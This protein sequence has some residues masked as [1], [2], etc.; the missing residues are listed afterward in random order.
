MTEKNYYQNDPDYAA[1]MTLYETGDFNGSLLL[2]DDLL[3]RY[4]KEAQL[5]QFKEDVELQIVLHQF[6]SARVRNERFQF[7]IILMVMATILISVAALL[8]QSLEQYRAETLD[9]LREEQALI[10]AQQLSSIALL[11]TQAVTFLTADKYEI[12]G[13]I[14]D[15]I[16]EIDADY[17]NLPVLRETQTYFSYLESLYIQTLAHIEA[18]EYTEAEQTLGEI[19]QLSENYRDIAQLRQRIANEQQIILVEQQGREAYQRQ[20]WAEVISSYEQY[21]LLSSQTLSNQ[22]KSELITAYSESII[23]LLADDDSAIDDV[24]QAEQYYKSAIALVPQDKEFEE[25][26]SNLNVLI[27]NLIVLKYTQNVKDLINTQPFSVDSINQAIRYLNA[28]YLLNPDNSSIKTDV[29]NA[30]LYRDGLRKFYEGDFLSSIERLEALKMVA[31]DFAGGR[32]DSI[33]YEAY[34][35]RGRQRVSYGLFADALQ[36]FESAEIIAWRYQD[37]KLMLFDAQANIGYV[38]TQLRL[39]DEAASY[40][41]YAFSFVEADQKLASQPSLSSLYQRAAAASQGGNEMT[42][43]QLYSQL[44]QDLDQALY[45]LT[46]V[47]VFKGDS[48][49]AVVEQQNSSLHA[50]LTV[51]QMANNAYLI[52]RDQTL[53]IPAIP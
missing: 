24:R 31:S 41:D 8:Y 44:W 33:L 52:T 42:A 47:M 20:D 25:E 45:A 26:R 36:Y 7:A 35:A 2:A 1:L 3:E 50:I 28:A 15:Q 37:N 38:F 40:F 51:N 16:E 5:V 14:L 17:N 30:E 29:T 10:D 4:P 23:L 13:E 11:E 32:I 53:Q 49:F 12:A 9:R 48:L 34:M 46:P 21:A 6:S 39:Y 27:L 18:G 22:M 19:S 43:A